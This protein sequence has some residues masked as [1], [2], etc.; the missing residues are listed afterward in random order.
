MYLTEFHTV[1]SV[2]LATIA[3]QLMSHLSLS[4]VPYP[5]LSATTGLKLQLRSPIHCAIFL[6]MI[7]IQFALTTSMLVCKWVEATPVDPLLMGL[8]SGGDTPL[9]GGFKPPEL[10]QCMWLRLCSPKIR[11]LHFTQY[12]RCCYEYA[13]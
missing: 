10:L 12:I 3:L 8:T 5:I 9:T 13:R 4:I 2:V 11:S 7:A 6:K 1:S